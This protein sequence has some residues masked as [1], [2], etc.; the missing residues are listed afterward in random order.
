MLS[1]PYLQ[2]CTETLREI[3]ELQNKC[4]SGQFTHV[5]A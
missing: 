3:A 1:L 5:Q 4:I 2:E